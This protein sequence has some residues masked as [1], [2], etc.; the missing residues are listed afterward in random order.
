MCYIM[1]SF[2]HMPD[3]MIPTYMQIA[4][5]HTPDGIVCAREIQRDA[6]SVEE[7]TSLLF[8]VIVDVS[9]MFEAMPDDDESSTRGTPREVLRPTKKNIVSTRANTLT[10]D[11]C[12]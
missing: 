1:V 2:A 12:H 11:I 4:D 7:K 10:P 6:G 9:S 3:E 8:I 5:R